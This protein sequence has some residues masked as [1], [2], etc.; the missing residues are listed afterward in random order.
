MKNDPIDIETFLALSEDEKCSEETLKRIDTQVL[1]QL[2]TEYV[3]SDEVATAIYDEII[4]RS[5]NYFEN[6][7]FIAKQK[8]L[9][10]PN[11]HKAIGIYKAVSVVIC[12][13]S[14]ITARYLIVIKMPVIGIITIALSILY[15]VLALATSE[16]IKLFIDIAYD[17]SEIKKSTIEFHR[18]KA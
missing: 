18:D 16:A 6:D 1:D 15:A 3:L 2:L 8:K 17:I 7:E 10:Y 4:L 5:P 14:I 9:R 13:S 11:L 12:L